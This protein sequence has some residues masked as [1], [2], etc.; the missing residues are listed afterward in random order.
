MKL[1]DLE[2]WLGLAIAF[3]TLSSF[4]KR[5]PGKA[6]GLSYLGKDI[7]SAGKCRGLKNNNPGNLRIGG[8]DW[9]GKIPIY[10]NTDGEF[11]QFESLMW[12]I[13][14]AMVN[15]R[16]AYFRVGFQTIEKILYKWAPPHE[17]DTEGYIISIERCTRWDRNDLIQW[18]MDN[19]VILLKCMFDIE[20]G[21]NVSAYIPT[22]IYAEAW[23]RL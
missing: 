11:E 7:C 12:G 22:S 23:N 14:A 8:S 15:L 6:P 16:N 19:I 2:R 1:T 4:V 13:R 20:N 10:Q 21:I 18:N 5:E 3:F 9:I 17:N